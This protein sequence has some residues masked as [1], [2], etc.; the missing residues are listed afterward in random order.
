MVY[1][2]QD[3][4]LEKFYSFMREFVDVVETEMYN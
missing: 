2:C 4:L 1:I 3:E